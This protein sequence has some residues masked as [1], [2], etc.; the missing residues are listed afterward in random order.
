MPKQAT[1]D[2]YEDGVEGSGDKWE[3]RVDTDRAENKFETN[4]DSEAAEDWASNA[5]DSVDDYVSGVAESFGLSESEVAVGDDYEDGVSDSDAQSEWQ[6]ETS[7]SGETWRDGVKG[8]GGEW[9]SNS[10]EAS[11]EWLQETKEGLKGN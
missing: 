10:K 2:G 9:E 4:V 5:Q 8:K 11:S 3:S 1:T 7:Q 6:S